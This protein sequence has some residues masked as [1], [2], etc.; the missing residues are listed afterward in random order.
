[1]N[2]QIIDVG[3]GLITAFL[4]V[5]IVVSAIQELAASIFATR[6]KHLEAGLRNLIEGQT[7]IKDI[8]LAD[9]FDFYNAIKNHP[10]ISHLSD[11]KR[12]PSYLPPENVAL[13]LISVVSQRA[14]LAGVTIRTGYDLI[15]SMP[16]SSL[17]NWLY[18]LI[19]KTQGD[20]GRLENAIGQQFDN[21]M[22]RVSGW[23]KRHI[24]IWMIGYG[25]L[26]AVV[27]NID[28]LSLASRLWQD[29]NL[30]ENAI[31]AAG[32]ANSDKPEVRE[33]LTKLVEL[34]K[35]SSL[36]IGWSKSGIDS[37]GR[38]K[39]FPHI[40][41]LAGWILTALAASLGAPFWFD[42]LGRLVKLRSTGN[43]PARQ[44]IEE[45]PTIA[46]KHPIVSPAPDLTTERN[47]LIDH[48]ALSNKDDPSYKPIG[49]QER[50]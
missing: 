6:S 15:D 43:K 42:L 12:F 49:L 9:G 38:Q 41:Q 27:L 22:D 39:T 21:T 14:K 33:I 45:S 18:P 20:I 11:G 32:I 34:E 40:H 10:L 4:V 26:V 8:A 17:K 23:Y 1:M 24:Q 13:A 48:Y 37:D 28:T 29:S 46:A 7:Q 19:N 2:T 16:D 44:E 30:R 50:W 3:I 31:A 35:T 36:P 25:F 5:S 47:T